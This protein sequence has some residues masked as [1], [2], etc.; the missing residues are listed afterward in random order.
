MDSVY[1]DFTVCQMGERP[2]AIDKAISMINCT[3]TIWRLRWYQEVIEKP[4][5]FDPDVNL[6]ALPNNL[7][8]TDLKT[9]FVIG[10]TA[11]R[12]DGNSRLSICDCSSHKALISE[13]EWKTRRTYDPPEIYSAFTLTNICFQA[14]INSN[15]VN[16]NCIGYKDYLIDKLLLK[17]LNLEICEDCEK[18]A[19][20]NFKYQVPDLRNLIDTLKRPR[21]YESLSMPPIVSLPV[22]EKQIERQSRANNTS[23]FEKYGIVIVMHFL[24]DLLPFI[25]GL[26]EL[27]AKEESIALLVK[28]YPYAQR[29]LL[30]SIICQQY[31]QV[32]LE[33]L[34]ELPPNEYLLS[35]VIMHCRDRS[36]G[37]IL[38]IEDGGYVVP[39]LHQS[40]TNGEDF[41][42]GAVE[43]TTKGLRQ[44]EAIK[45]NFLF[46]ILN[47]AKSRFKDEYESPLVG[48]AVVSSIQRLLPDES[49]SGKKA[50]VVGFGS[51]GREVAHAL[52]ATGMIVM[53][54][55][56][57][58][59]A[60]AAAKVRGFEASLDPL[61]LIQKADLVVGTT[62]RNSI[63]GE[64]IDAMKNGVTI[65]STSSDLVEIDIGHL[66][67]ISDN[68]EYKE[69]LGT[70]YSKGNE[71]SQHTYL[72]LADGF[73]VNF[74]SGLGIPNKA[75]DPILTQMFIGAIHI[76]NKHQDLDPGIV[77]I[78][79]DLDNEY[80]LTHDFLET[81]GH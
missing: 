69:G 67:Q 46:P 30:H 81:Y 26:I 21:A 33:Y 72:L 43:Q 76:A 39:F 40:Y 42:V 60:I 29:A 27:G 78:M 12:V 55:D 80:Q 79:E 24:P 54:N 49:F 51:V 9:S 6:A 3:Q 37:Q 16:S 71:L 58:P 36:S 63:R 41:C 48:R 31:P 35:E 8:S 62:G 65:A 61:A 59:N 47:V 34:D 70:F 19:L 2:S 73:P 28:P 23:V 56:E 25:Q 53:V 13:Y 5:S 7:M 64:M 1:K 50:L 15:C 45:R 52:R 14:S 18:H 77:S 10:V 57:E 11:G 22:L 44:D 38:V 68:Q 75:I 20:S 17:V 66:E 4:S 74:F 32:R